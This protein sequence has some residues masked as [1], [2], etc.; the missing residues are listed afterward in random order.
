M[1]ADIMWPWWQTKGLA[2]LVWVSTEQ[3]L[4]MPGCN[5]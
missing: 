3:R 4:A 2:A 1:L 5:G